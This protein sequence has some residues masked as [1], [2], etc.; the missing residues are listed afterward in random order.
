MIKSSLKAKNDLKIKYSTI[1]MYISSIKSYLN[2]TFGTDIVIQDALKAQQIKKLPL[3][4]Y[5]C[6]SSDR[7]C[8]IYKQA[9]FY[10]HN[11]CFYEYG[12]I[13]VFKLSNIGWIETVHVCFL[14]T[15]DIPTHF[16]APNFIHIRS[17][18]IG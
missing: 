6:C 17:G 13:I 4:I 7:F 3:S 18:I 5:F 16:V 12:C 11:Q 14:M 10:I 15:N 1:A 9:N 8:S 2:V